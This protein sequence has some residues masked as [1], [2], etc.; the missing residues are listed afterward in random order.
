M[1]VLC[2]DLLLSLDVHTVEH[3]QLRDVEEHLQAVV[4]FVHDRV[5]AHFQLCEE[6]QLLDIAEL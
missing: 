6:R 2:L 4:F 5:E 3:A 1:Q